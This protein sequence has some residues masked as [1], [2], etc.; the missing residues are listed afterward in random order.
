VSNVLRAS[1]D[2]YDDSEPSYSNKNVAPKTRRVNI[3]YGTAWTRTALLS[4]K[5]S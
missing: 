4:E 1:I 5:V 3:S 2:D